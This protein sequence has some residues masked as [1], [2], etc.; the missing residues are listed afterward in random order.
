MAS[1]SSGLQSAPAAE[2]GLPDRQAGL[3]ASEPQRESRGMTFQ[4]QLARSFERAGWRIRVEDDLDFRWKIDLFGESIQRAVFEDMVPS[5]KSAP[6]LF[7]GSIGVQVTTDLRVGVKAALFAEIGSVV[8]DRLVY[9]SVEDQRVTP[10]DDYLADLLTAVIKAWP[11]DDVR[12]SWRVLGIHV[13]RSY[14]LDVYDLLQ[15]ISVHRKVV[16]TNIGKRF[17]GRVA[18]FRSEKNFGNI[19]CELEED[20]RIFSFYFNLAECDEAA[21]VRLQ[22]GDVGFK[23]TFVND[24][25]RDPDASHEWPTAKSV[26]LQVNGAT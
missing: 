15:R 19:D 6:C 26:V 22:R 8:C 5:V 17:V 12:A 25:Y 7:R 18:S 23:V 13:R 4:N 1:V 11:F 20:G 2:A 21:S 9:V 16:E 10:P 24:G 14:R 3:R